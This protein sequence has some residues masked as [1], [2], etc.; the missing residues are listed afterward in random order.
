MSKGPNLDRRRLLVAAAVTIAVAQLS[1]IGSAG[2]QTSKTKSAGLPVIKPGTNTSFG[3]LKQIH[4]GLLTVGYAEAGPHCITWTHAEEVTAE[5]L[6]FLGEKDNA[7][8]SAASLKPCGR[9]LHRACS[10]VRIGR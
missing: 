2:A 4:A 6:S 8:R 5:R 3:S 10:G 9:Q 1:L 7:T